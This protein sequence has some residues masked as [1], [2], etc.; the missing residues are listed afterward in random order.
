M[1]FVTPILAFLALVLAWLAYKRSGAQARAIEEA[2]VDAR[3]AAKSVATELGAALEVQKK[4]LA[5]VA[6]GEKLTR[7]MILEGQL[8]RD[9]SAAEGQ[10]MLADERGLVLVD[11]RTPAETRSGILPGAR[12]IP[13]DQLEARAGELPKSGVPILIYCAGGGR[14]AAAC[15]H[16]S[17]AGFEGLHNLEGGFSSWTGPRAMP[18]A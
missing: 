18:P 15:E 13:I 1:E 7:E 2:G 4:L 9:V 5:R 11:V 14:S 16:L 17:R 8:W 3:R 10:R 6:A 12:L